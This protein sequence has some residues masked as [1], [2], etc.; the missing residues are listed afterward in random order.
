MAL[1]LWELEKQKRLKEKLDSGQPLTATETF[2]ARSLEFMGKDI[3][4][5]H[6]LIL[7]ALV[8]LAKT[9][10]GLKV[11][12]SLGKEFLKGLFSTLHALGQ[13]SA[14]NK[15][16]SWANP[17]LVAL[18]LDRF[19][20][21]NPNYLLEYKVGLSLISGAS[22]AEGFLDNIQGIFPFSKPEPAEYPQNITFSPS[23]VQATP[24]SE[25]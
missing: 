9:P 22:I 17:Y 10:G 12:E 5:E 23:S 11:I 6:F 25:T 7:F 1:A 21:I 20:F 3:R 18:V 13:A 14:A 24:T 16:A 15:V 19:G 4:F 2:D 8:K